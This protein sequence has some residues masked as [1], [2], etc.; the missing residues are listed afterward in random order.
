MNWKQ[1]VPTNLE[2][3]FGEDHLSRLIYIECLL[4]ATNV[5]R[6]VNRN[7]K[8][9][10]LKRGQCYFTLTELSKRLDRNIK[11]IKKYIEICKNVHNVM[12]NDIDRFGAVISIKNYDEIISMDNIADNERITSGQ[13][14]PINK[15]EKNEKNKE[16]NKIFFNSLSKQDKWLVENGHLKIVNGKLLS[17]LLGDI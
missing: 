1:P 3:I 14:V 6:V 16:K 5:E 8:I 13:R 11:T 9:T 17:P 10:T 15:N 2:S 12:D 7:G 4:K